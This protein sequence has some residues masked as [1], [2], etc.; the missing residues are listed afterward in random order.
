VVGA[1]A[2]LTKEG[3]AAAQVGHLGVARVLGFGVVP[4]S[5]VVGGVAPGFGVGLGFGV[6]EWVPIA[7]LRV[8]NGSAPIVGIGVPWAQVVRA[9]VGGHQTFGLIVTTLVAPAV[10]GRRAVGVGF[11]SVVADPQ[12]GVAGQ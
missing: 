5:G 3:I 4:F 9:A 1:I 6:E 10:P 12:L 11:T 7:R 8:P 2:A